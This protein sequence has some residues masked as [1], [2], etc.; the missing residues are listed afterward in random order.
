MTEATTPLPCQFCGHKFVSV[1]E[2]SSSRWRAAMC[3]ECGAQGP[4]ERCKSLGEGSRKEWEEECLVRCVE[5]WNKRADARRWTLP[6]KGMPEEGQEVILT[7]MFDAREE[8]S[9]IAGRRD[10][11]RWIGTWFDDSEPFQ[12]IF[13]EVMAWMPYPPPIPRR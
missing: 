13:G 10:G 4:E 5:A 9:V 3:E 7:V 11:D 12:E 6:S 2:T 1:V 8:D